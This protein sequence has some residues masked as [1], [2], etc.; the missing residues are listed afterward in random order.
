MAQIIS[1][2]LEYHRPRIVSHGCRVARHDNLCH[3]AIGKM[4]HQF[5]RQNSKPA[6]LQ[7]PTNTANDGFDLD[8]L[9]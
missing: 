9:G 3:Q 7:P 4:V 2:A 5:L 6:N 1:R 8:G